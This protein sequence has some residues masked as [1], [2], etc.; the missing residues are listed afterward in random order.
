MANGPDIPVDERQVAL[1]DPESEEWTRLLSAPGDQR[2]AAIARLYP[3]LLRVARAEARRRAGRFGIDGPEI[4]DIAHQAASD[5]LIAIVAKLETFR[6]ESRFTTWAYKFVVF[7]VSTKL[8]RH[9]W[10]APSTAMDA[11]GWERL[12]DRFG[13][14]P[15]RE[16]ERRV[17]V[18]AMRVAVE[19]TLTVHQREVFVAIVLQGTPL[20]VVVEQQG[21]NR[22]AIY[23]TLF[24]ARRK[25]RGA[26]AANGHLE[27]E[28]VK[29]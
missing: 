25:L 10:R 11:E 20:D 9:F 26:L 28:G 16:Y 18:D 21:S 5:A 12:P 8:R 1:P 4:D 14:E 24:D 15:D 6:G 22:N 13:V 3:Y 27:I 29:G 19:S 23:K 2:D 7:E 17:L